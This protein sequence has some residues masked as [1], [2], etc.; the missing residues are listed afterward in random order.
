MIPIDQAES[1][2]KTTSVG[3]CVCAWFSLFWSVNVCMHVFRQSSVMH[4]DT[5]SSL[6]APSSL[7]PSSSSSWLY[8]ISKCLLCSLLPSC[9]ALFLPLLFLFC[10]SCAILQFCGLTPSWQQQYI[11]SVFSPAAILFQGQARAF[12]L[13]RRAALFTRAVYLAGHYSV[14]VVHFLLQRKLGYYLIQTYIPLIMVVVL[15]QVS[16]WINKE[17]VPAR[18][19]AGMPLSPPALSV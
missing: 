3:L 17:S 8:P 11:Y 10:H 1:K 6:L 14:Q 19:V 4:S 18:T 15:S 13:S 7:N 16:F 2:R 9:P 12:V 5:G